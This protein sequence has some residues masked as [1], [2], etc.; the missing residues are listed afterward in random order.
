[1]NTE[2][3]EVRKDEKL[4]E[5]SLKAFFSDLLKSKINNFSLKQ[6]SGG[7][8]NLTYLISVNDE[9]YV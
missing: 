9:E 7:H 1:M 3:I 4:N 2:L 5:E 8:A 6:F